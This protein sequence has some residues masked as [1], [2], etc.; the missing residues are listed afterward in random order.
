MKLLYFVAPVL[1]IVTAVI[2]YKVILNYF[3]NIGNIFKRNPLMGI[4]AGVLSAFFLSC[5]SWF[6][7]RSSVIIPQIG[8][9]SKGN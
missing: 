7:I 8:K 9:D 3:K 1:I 5:C 4:G 2:N 6:F